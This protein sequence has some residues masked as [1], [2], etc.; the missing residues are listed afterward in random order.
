MVAPAGAP[1]VLN[2]PVRTVGGV[3]A[4]A[5]SE[6]GVVDGGSAG[7]GGDNTTGVLLEDSLVSFDG[8]GVWLDHNSGL[9]KSVA[10]TSIVVGSRALSVYDARGEGGGVASAGNTDLSRG[11]GVGGSRDLGGCL[12]VV[13]CIEV[14]ATVATLVA[15]GGRAGNELL[16]G[17]VGRSSVVLD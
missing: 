6:D 17:L 14:P 13:P 3:S 10:T 5:D 4:I 7:G 16:L 1:G 11:V 9:H 12:H 15:E 2:E 8:D